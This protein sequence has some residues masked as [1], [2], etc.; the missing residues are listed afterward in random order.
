ML[1][2]TKNKLIQTYGIND[3]EFFKYI[4]A[5]KAFRNL[6]TMCNTNITPV[7]KVKELYD[8][9][10]YYKSI[11]IDYTNEVNIKEIAS[12]KFRDLFLD[13]GDNSIVYKIP[14]YDK[15][16]DSQNF[17]AVAIS[18]SYCQ[19]RLRIVKTTKELLVGDVITNNIPIPLTEFYESIYINNNL[20]KRLIKLTP[21]G[22]TIA[23]KNIPV[24]SSIYGCF[25]YII[26]Y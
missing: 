21:E 5:H 16:D 9:F 12:R 11:G 26:S 8:R 18:H 23:D 2:E 10:I 24:G 7:D 4:D 25:N 1:E 22:L 17:S 15:I 19:I 14:F 6:V 13:T 3:D 20:E